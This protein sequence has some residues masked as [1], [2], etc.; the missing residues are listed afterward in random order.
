MR[1]AFALAACALPS[2]AHASALEIYGMGARP[3]AMGQAAT[4]A[5]DGP[6]AAHYNPAALA[7]LTGIRFDAGYRIA[8]AALTL[9]GHDIGA[10]N[11]RSTQLSLG[12]GT[13]TF[14]MP[15]GLGLSVDV[16][17]AGLYG[18]RLRDPASPQFVLVDARRDR[19]HAVIGFGIQPLEKLSAGI[20]ASLF[21]DTLAHIGID[22]GADPG[23]TMDASLEPTRT[24]HAGVR[25]G[26]WAGVTFGLTYRAEEYSH[27]AFPT[28]LHAKVGSVDGEVSV[29]SDNAVFFT[30]AEI[31]IGVAKQTPAWTFAADLLASR[32]SRMRD[33]NGTQIITVSGTPGLPPAP[34]A[35]YEEDPRF[36]DTLSPRAGAEWRRGALALRGGANFVPT[37]APAPSPTR[38]LV[39]C[40]RTGLSAGAAWTLSAPSLLTGP[41][42]L[43]AH[44]TWSHL[45]PRTVRRDDPSDPVGSYRAAG[46]LWSFGI[47]A[48]LRFA[49]PYLRGETS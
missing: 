9:N 46:E 27:L 29:Q 41:L 5:V 13:K 35:V 8:P 34:P 30:P 20:G 15:S 31:A 45:L 33:P 24:V 2:I 18:V 26:P 28:D 40:S 1:L 21:A 11:A 37:P 44:A 22:F 3:S 48:S 49:A 42:T 32:W 12:L 7:S 47:T 10:R 19:M 16:P 25:A 23:A 36:H 6:E 43:D 17:D 4:A 14:G 39:D 38:N